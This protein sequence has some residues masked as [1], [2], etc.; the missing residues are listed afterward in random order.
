MNISDPRKAYR[1]SAIQT[2]SM[3]DV[4][5]QLYDQ[6]SGLLHSAAHAIEA[7]DIDKKTADVGRAFTILIHL[8]GALDFERGGEVAVNLNQFY[9]LVRKEVSEGSVKLDAALLRQAGAHIVELRNLWERAQ[10]ITLRQA[11]TAPPASIPSPNQAARPD[12]G[13]SFAGSR[14]QDDSIEARG[15]NA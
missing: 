1:Q 13:A 2:E 10:A 7:R 15:W 12:V 8:Q 3:A 5:I 6:L 14:S 4:F 9:R 11:A